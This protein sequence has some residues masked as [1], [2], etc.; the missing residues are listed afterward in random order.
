MFQLPQQ[1]KKMPASC[2]LFKRS[3]WFPVLN[4]GNTTGTKGETGREEQNKLGLFH[5]DSSWGRPVVLHRHWNWAFVFRH[6]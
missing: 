1:L 4:T 6:G 5:P 2:L 3:C